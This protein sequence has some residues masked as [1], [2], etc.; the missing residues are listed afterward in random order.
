M[1]IDSHFMWVLIDLVMRFSYNRI[2]VS[3]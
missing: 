2:R 3:H 1:R